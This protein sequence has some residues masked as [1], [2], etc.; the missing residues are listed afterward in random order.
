MKYITNEKG[1]C[2]SIENHKFYKLQEESNGEVGYVTNQTKEVHPSKIRKRTETMLVKDK[3]SDD[4]PTVEIANTSD[5][6]SDDNY[7]PPLKKRKKGK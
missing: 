4:T 1:N 2:L 6:L 5:S 7:N 3:V